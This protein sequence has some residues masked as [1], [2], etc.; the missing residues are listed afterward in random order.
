MIAIMTIMMKR[1]QLVL[2]LV[3]SVLIVVTSCKP[4]KKPLSE[5]IAKTWVAQSV[6][7]D[8]TLVYEKGGSGGSAPGY[9]G[10]QL[11]L[12]PDHTVTLIEL[13]GTTFTGTWELQGETRLILKDLGPQPPT[14]SGGKLE[15]TI[16]SIEDNKLVL[17]SVSP[18]VKTGNTVNEY[19][20]TVK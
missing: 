14:S 3:F 12:N 19:S 1:L 2:G 16:K 5:R 6:K 4:K 9:S 11:I 13:D 8:N 10:Y 18:S 7:H 17:L 20:L 15:Y